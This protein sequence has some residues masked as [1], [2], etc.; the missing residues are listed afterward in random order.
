MSGTKEFQKPC[1]L[2]GV[3]QV[4]LEHAGKGN[5]VGVV[6]RFEQSRHVQRYLTRR[7]QHF[8][9][10]HVPYAGLVLR[11]MH[12]QKPV[13][14]LDAPFKAGVFQQGL[15]AKGRAGDVVMPLVAFHAA[16]LELAADGPDRRNLGPG[17]LAGVF[18]A[19]LFDTAQ[20]ARFLGF[21][22]SAPKLD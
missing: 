20:L 18:K 16:F 6:G 13:H 5:P 21:F 3:K 17:P 14:R 10:I 7:V 11:E 2:T 4:R 22:R 15:R 1:K 9:D 19:N 12:V 8:L